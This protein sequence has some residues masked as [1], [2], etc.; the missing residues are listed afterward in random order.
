MA[1]IV[2]VGWITKIV[3]VGLV[4]LSVASI[5]LILEKRKQ[6]KQCD[7]F[8]EISKLRSFLK[9]EQNVKDL[10][11]HLVSSRVRGNYLKTIL[12]TSSGASREHVSKAFLLEQ[13]LELESKLSILST[14]AANAPY[15]G[16]FGTILGIIQSFGILAQNEAGGTTLIMASIAEA[17]IATAVGILVAIPAIVGANTFSR[18]IKVI[19][20]ECESLFELAE[21]RGL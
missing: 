13:R 15:V 2:F 5:A 11:V 6:F 14:I 8:S 17:L 21:S 12:Q 18:T 7:D 9:S 16:L 4:G 19:L 3:L 20:S 1:W 10:N